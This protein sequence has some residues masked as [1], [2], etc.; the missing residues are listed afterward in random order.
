ML[1]MRLFETL[2]NGLSIL[3]GSF[4]L[5][6]GRVL[7]PA[8]KIN[9]KTIYLFELIFKFVYESYLLLDLRQIIYEFSFKYF[10]SYFVDVTSEICLGRFRL[11]L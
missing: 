10:K 2:V 4:V 5:E 11:V 3:A 6:V 7:H 8:L 1:W 9:V